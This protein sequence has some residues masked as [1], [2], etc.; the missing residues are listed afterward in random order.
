VRTRFRQ[1]GA[2]QQKQEIH[3]SNKRK[4]LEARNALNRHSRKCLVCH[5]PDRDFIEE[6]FLHWRSPYAIASQFKISDYRSLYRH[7]RATGILDLRRHNFFSALDSLVEAA[8]EAKVTGDCVIRAIRA[9]SCLDSRGHWV[10]PPTQV[11]FSTNA[12]PSARPTARPSQSSAASTTKSTRVIDIPEPAPT[13]ELD[14][15]SEIDSDSALAVACE[16][17]GDSNSDSNFTPDPAFIAELEA[18][19]ASPVP[20]DPAARDLNLIYRRAIRTGL[21]ALKT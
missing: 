17:N 18:L 19:L 8:E 10:D 5:H 1:R 13:S 21:N 11:N 20:T 16:S 2:P 9:Y 7:A 15:E 12:I 6:E 14:S 4:S 3:V